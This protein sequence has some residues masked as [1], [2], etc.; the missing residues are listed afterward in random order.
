M[1]S[2]FDSD[3]IVIICSSMLFNYF[4]YAYDDVVMLKGYV[5][6]IIIYD[7]FAIWIISNVSKQCDGYI[8]C[9]SRPF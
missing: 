1:F 5:W 3:L 4:Y 7:N 6:P 9:Q 8:M 2:C